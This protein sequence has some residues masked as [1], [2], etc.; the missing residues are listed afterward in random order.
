MVPRSTLTDNVPRADDLANYKIASCGD[1]VINRMSA[2]QGALGIA[3]QDG[4]V[5]PE[6][7]VLRPGPT[8]DGRFL[9]Y[10]FKSSWFVSQMTLR[11]R[12]IGGTEQGNVRT[13]RINPEDLGRI[14]VAI[15]SKDEQQV[16]AD[17][18]DAETARI[19]ALVERRS[20][21]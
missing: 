11:L 10:L 21:S 16:I 17:Y 18:L 20:G 13:P 3:L 4:T 14:P 8:V 6:Y 12:G 9:T 19:D 2:Y 15:P 1:I 5:S 7:I